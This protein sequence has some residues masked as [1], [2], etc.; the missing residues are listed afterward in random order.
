[1]YVLVR[2][3]AVRE[4]VRGIKPP[5]SVTL[6]RPIEKLS[7]SRVI[8]PGTGVTQPLCFR[9][10]GF[11]APQ[12]FLSAF[13]LGPSRAR[14]RRLDSRLPRRAP[15]QLTRARDCHLC[16]NTPSR[17]DEKSRLTAVPPLRIHPAHA[18]R[19]GLDR[20][21][22]SDAKQHLRDCTAACTNASLA[23]TMAPSR[24]QMQTPRML[25]SIRRRILPSLERATL[26]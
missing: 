19:R 17:P 4:A 24:F 23:S 6:I 1:M 7:G 18:N 25:A 9:Q 22:A 26:A 15:R 8:G 11:A 5:D 16:G 21:S 14:K 20:S 10:I 12:C 13:A 3:F 2:D